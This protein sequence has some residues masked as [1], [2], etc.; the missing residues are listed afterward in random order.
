MEEKNNY[1]EC[2]MYFTANSLTRY[3][4]T[5]ADNAFRPTGL[6]PSYGHLM[7]ILIEE[8]GLTQNELSARMNVKASTM[9]RFLEKLIA[10]NYAERVQEG[11][12]MHVYPTDSGKALH[13]PILKALSDLH[14]NYCDVLGKEVA[15]KM[16]ADM[17]IANRKLG[18]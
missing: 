14:K 11:R 16:I 5:M 17:A 8:P 3:I 10:Q 12:S 4:N 15:E 7:M 6:A 2:C 18:E 13:D 9:T 1:Q